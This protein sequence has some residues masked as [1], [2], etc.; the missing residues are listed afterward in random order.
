MWDEVIGLID[1]TAAKKKIVGADVVELSPRPGL[2][3]ADFAAAKLAYKVIARS[4]N[5]G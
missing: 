5:K 4:F 3:Y 2:D 1:K